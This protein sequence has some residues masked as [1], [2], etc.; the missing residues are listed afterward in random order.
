MLV[1]Q[2]VFL[3][4]P[5]YIW[6][7]IINTMM[8]LSL[9]SSKITH[10]CA[11]ERSYHNQSSSARC[12]WPATGSSSLPSLMRSASSQR[13]RAELN[14]SGFSSCTQ[15][16]AGIFCNKRKVSISTHEDPD[17][18]PFFTS[19]LRFGT[20][21]SDPRI[22]AATSQS[23]TGSSVGNIESAGCGIVKFP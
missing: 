19:I 16:A 7:N 3:F 20:N 6:Y 17:F 18:E 21:F 15:C 9:K 2:T 11:R 13:R 23:A 5:I 22:F 12:F 4:I 1:L 10:I 8:V 14:S